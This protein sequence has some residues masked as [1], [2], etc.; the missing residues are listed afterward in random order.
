MATLSTTSEPEA[1]ELG[2]ISRPLFPSCM[3]LP[4]TFLLTNDDGI[5]AP[6][7]RAL[8]A[9]LNGA[10]VIVAPNAHLSGCSHQLTR[11]LPISIERRSEREFALGG[12]PADCTRVGLS[13]IY[14]EA[15]FVLSGINAGG[16]L[17][18]DI[19]V[20]GTVAAVREAALMRVPGIA[21]SHYIKNR[22]PIDWAMAT[23]LTMQA[24]DKLL[25][26]PT[27]PGTFWN[28]NLPHLAADAPSPDIVMC[29]TCTQPLPLQ[30]QVDG[31]Q[32]RF[33]GEYGQRPRDPGADV[34]VCFSGHIAVTKIRLW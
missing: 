13:Y 30:Y 1:A 11:G 32:F 19:H 18:A 24:L 4:M 33:T 27:E 14:P 7:I 17:G 12:T 26:L 15:Q 8:Q 31:D 6:G 29:Q 2:E 23:R 9:A 21:I 22:Q 10:G 20:S 5:D 25:T 28:V 34:E 16:N 3:F